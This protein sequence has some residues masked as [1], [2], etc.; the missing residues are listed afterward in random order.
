MTETVPETIARPAAIDQ[1]EIEFFRYALSA[2]LNELELSLVQSA[3]SPLIYEYKDFAVGVLSPAFELMNHSS[4]STPGFL[5]DLGDTVRDAVE[6]VGSD[7]LGPG[8]AILTN[9]AA[10][11]GQHLNN[12][13][14]IA[15]LYQSEAKVAYLAIRAH[16]SDIGGIEPGSMSWRA[17]E[18]YHEG[19][20]FRGMRVMTAGQLLPEAVATCVA[21][22]RLEDYIRGDLTAQVGCCLLGQTRWNDRIASRWSPAYVAQLWA[23]QREQSHALAKSRIR[24]LPD[25][26]YHASCRTDDSG[27]AGTES[28]ELNV[29]VTIEGDSMTIDLTGYP[30]QV[31]API[32]SGAPRRHRVA[33]RALIA[34][35]YP[36]DEGILSAVEVRFRPGT[37]ISAGKG[38]AMGHWNSAG[39]NLSDLIYRAIGEKHPEK[40]PAGHH[41]SMNV[42]IFSGR[43]ANGSW[44]QTI[45][46]AGGGWGGHARADGFSP[47]KTLGHGDNKDIPVEL[48]EGRFPLRV[49]SL[50]YI[51][52]SGGSGTHRGG[53]GVRRRITVLDTVYLTTSM[54]RTLD[55]PWGLSGGESGRP[56]S[57][58]IRQAGQDSWTEST[59]VSML[60][61]QRG[62]EVEICTAGGGGWGPPDG[63]PAAACELDRLNGFVTGDGSRPPAPGAARTRPR[64]S[65][66][67]AAFT[68][69]ISQWN[70][71]SPD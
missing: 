62:S 69:R 21:N 32:N 18:I 19:M 59:K 30:D 39:P 13:V 20:Q 71:T 3:Y 68:W 16:W 11:Q 9:Y 61:L 57:V 35:D 50:E 58:R 34:P 54:D 24:G 23:A 5:A 67:T 28:L 42:F 45:D 31:T 40:V 60:E 49:D 63:R 29:G 26:R 43:G 4:M 47:L 1:L 10:V 15:P 46:T 70:E 51:P 64:A 55:P 2:V 25:G 52:D 6:I 37:I 33:C 48:I 8:D 7:R 53:L 66:E 56:G 12:M 65:V 36:I 22:S 27:L 17:T 38:A 14:I 41:A 44:W